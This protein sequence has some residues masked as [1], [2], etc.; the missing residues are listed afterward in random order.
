[1]NIKNTLKQNENQRCFDSYQ[2]VLDFQDKLNA[3]ITIINPENQLENAKEGKL[4]KIPY[5]LKDNVST[6]DILTTAGSRIL[7]N[8][9]PSYDATI[10]K[11]LKEAGAI[12]VSKASLD[13][14]AMGGTN[15]SAFIGPCYNPYDLTRIS[16]GSSGGS[17]VLVSSGAVSFS[18]G[19]DTGDS[20]RKPASF[21][22]VVGVKPSY[23]RISRYGVIPYASSLDHVGYF[24]NNV[25]DASLI[26]EVLAGRD[27]KD[28]T[29]SYE[30]VPNYSQLLTGNVKNKKILVFK[31]VVNAV[32]TA[33]AKQI[34]DSFNS[35]INKL[36]EKGALVE[37][38]EFNQDLMLALFPTYYVISNCEATANHAN[39]DGIRFGHK[40]DGKN[41]QE[42]MTNTRTRGFSPYVKKRFII[43]S[44]GLFDRNQEFVLKKAQRVRR[45]IVDEVMSKLKN[46]D[47]LIA[48]ASLT[49]APKVNDKNDNVFNEE[50]LI[51]ENHM[52]IGN[53]AGL[54]SMTLPM[55]Y[56]DDL[57]VGVNITCNHFKEVDMFN[58]AKAI[59]E[60]SEVK[61]VIKEDF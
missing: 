31:N 55:S 27:D 56:V 57:P 12:C 48:P 10:F 20:V 42:I 53:F 22:N 59:E 4:F 47:C 17:A 45:L 8:Y 5:A 33:Q 13:E 11:K 15:L 61:D 49:V 25:E 3:S 58:I 52:I 54:P 1:M 39:L 2:K 51:A 29:S 18:I 40:V 21:C 32:K 24:T 36:K 43:G 16:G 30:E 60:V 50:Y 44:Y 28:L 6:K 37:E 9:V 46:A 38:V 34:V 26:L 19:S 35:L 14:L 23:G 7:D 41:I